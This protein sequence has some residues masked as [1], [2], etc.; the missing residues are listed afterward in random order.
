MYSKLVCGLALAVG[1]AM[2]RPD[3]AHGHGG[4]SAQA[5]SAGYSAPASPS[6]GYSAP[7]QSY[8]APAASYGA[9]ATGYGASD[10]VQQYDSSYAV[11]GYGAEEEPF[12]IATLIIPILI[13]AGLSLLFPTI[14]TVSVRKKRSAD[15][16]KKLYTFY[17]LL[18]HYAPITLHYFTLQKHTNSK[19]TLLQNCNYY[20]LCMYRNLFIKKNYV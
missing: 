7:A 5:S 18:L 6:N 2:G 4:H 3:G 17:T 13:I 10:E 9:P 20:F 12:N 16:G 11:S 8:D 19:T 1:T 15:D 14:T